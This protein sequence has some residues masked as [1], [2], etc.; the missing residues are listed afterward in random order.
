MV[1]KSKEAMSCPARVPNF[2]PTRHPQLQFQIQSIQLFVFEYRSVFL[3]KRV[4]KN[5]QYI[6]TAH[7]QP[8]L[9]GN[10]FGALLSN[11]EEEELSGADT[12]YTRRETASPSTADMLMKRQEFLIVHSSMLGL[13]WDD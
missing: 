5:T 11:S 8:G 13:G 10:L 6:R 4:A 2:S 7:Q 1:V 12:P 3:V 9:F